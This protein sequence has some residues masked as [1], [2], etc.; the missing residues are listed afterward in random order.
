M[1]IRAFSV[2]QF[3][4][5]KGGQA[6]RLMGLLAVISAGLI[7]RSPAQLVTSS[8]L[9]DIA[10]GPGN[11]STVI[12]WTAVPQSGS[13][14]VIN[15]GALFPAVVNQ[16]VDAAVTEL[17]VGSGATLNV[18]SGRRLDV[19]GNSTIAGTLSNAGTLTLQSGT[20]TNTGGTINALTGSSV[21]VTNATV[22]G[23]NFTISGTGNVRLSGATV[24]ASIVNSATGVIRA[25]SGVNTVVGFYSDSLGSQIRIDN[26]AKILV[27]TGAAAVTVNGGIYLD[28]TGTDTVWEI[29]A[30]SLTIGGT[31]KLVLSNNPNNR[32]IGSNS[33][34]AVTF[35]PNFTVQGAGQIGNALL[36]FTNQ[37]SMIADQSNSLIVKP[38]ALGFSNSGTLRATNGATLV[39]QS[40]TFTNSGSGTIIADDTSHVDIAASTI[41]GGTLSSIGT[42]HFHALDSSTLSG[43]A[44]SAGSRVEVGDG[45]V[46]T[47]LGNIVNDGVITLLSTGNTTHVKI[48]SAAT[49]NGAGNVTLSDSAT[50]RISAT[51]AGPTLTIGAN[52]TISGAGQLG[53][54]TLALTNL[55][56]IA[57]TGN[58]AL[59]LNN[60]G[61]AFTNSGTLK[62]SGA[63]GLALEDPSITNQGNILI[64]NG[65]AVTANGTFTQAG[66]SSLLQIA[67]G[68]FTASTFA[69]QGGTLAGTGTLVGPV[70]ATGE[71]SIQ[72]GGFGS[73]GTLTFNQTLTLGAS[74]GLYF[75]LGGTTPGTGYDRVNG[76]AMVLNGTLFVSFANQFE[77]SIVPTDSFTLI[78]TSAA[79]SG[80]FS[81]V[82]NGG[83]L[84]TLD[85]LGSFQVNYLANALTL[86]SFQAVP[87]PS[88]YALFSLGAIA[89]A[90]VELRRRRRS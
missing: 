8:W 57:A 38:G 40:G 62:S 1:N 22:S 10:A 73:I 12:Y 69:L 60:A 6:I 4:F 48:D 30:T 81:N 9:P 29:G 84:A 3:E 66:G 2:Q 46:L 78:S 33:S 15:N 88:T 74:T 72:P 25:V 68:T 39:L 45:Q 19:T 28:S 21:E 27:P 11:W 82:S 32:V 7:S 76:A 63:G 17:T 67:N 89:V 55:G 77:F 36:T 34:A 51:V 41:S 14:V 59:V 61:A 90:M 87:E 80:S 37:G 20:F 18:G 54:N 85:G 16:D 65:S 83:R 86:S 71:A 5:R 42:G 47:L 56:T 50:N 53:G 79:L 43:V 64:S 52:Q 70:T 44:I 31:G 35:G 13:K 26:G 24:G 23:G 58:N 75:D 49:L